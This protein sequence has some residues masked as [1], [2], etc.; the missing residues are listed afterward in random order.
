MADGGYDVRDYCDID[1][2]FGTLAD[3][4]ALLADAHAL[5]LRV[6][7]DLVANHTSERAPLVHRRAGRRAGVA[8][9]AALLLPRRPGRR[10][11]SRPTTGSAPSAGRP[12]PGSPTPDGRPGQWYLHTVRPR[13]ARPRLGRAGRAGG[14]RRHPAVLAGPRRR[15]PPRRRGAGDGEGARAA[16]RRP[17]AGR[18]FESRSWVD[19]PHW[20][21]DGVHD[22]LR[23]W[24]AIGDGYAGDRLFVTEAVVRTPSGSAATCGPTRC[25]RAS[26]STT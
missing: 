3:A 13:A 15:R 17:R 6:I 1:P 24:R 26:T 23:R 16:R 19:S 18:A 12:G 14:L 4:D 11:A 25:T 10:G 9:A 22:I 8:G 7:I 21:V 5:G 2:R 20:D